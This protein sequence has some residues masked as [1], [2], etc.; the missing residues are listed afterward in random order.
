M[1]DFGVSSSFYY[2]QNEAMVG[3]YDMPFWMASFL[4]SALAACALQGFFVIFSFLAKAPF[5]VSEL[6]GGAVSPRSKRKDKQIIGSFLHILFLSLCGIVLVDF[7]EVFQ[8][9]DLSI[10]WAVFL[11]SFLIWIFEG[12]IAAPML[13]AGVMGYLKHK[14]TWAILLLSFIFYG[15]VFA[16]LLPLIYLS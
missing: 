5:S 4:A 9:G 8:I 16:V 13:G 2:I 12:V 3:G 15:L 14:F 10:L 6:I 1:F 11:F 7:I